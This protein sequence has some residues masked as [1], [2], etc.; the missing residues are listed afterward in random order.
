MPGYWLNEKS[1]GNRGTFYVDDFLLL[2]GQQ[3]HPRS[4]GKIEIKVKV[5]PCICL[6]VLHASEFKNN[7]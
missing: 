4:T 3:K 1:P 7:Q 2:S 6:C 5:K